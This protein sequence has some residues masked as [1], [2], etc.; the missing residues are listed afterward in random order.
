M[1]RPIA[2][3]SGYGIVLGV[4]FA[5]G[6]MLAAF[7]TDVGGA[8]ESDESLRR[9]VD[10]VIALHRALRPFDI[11]VA[12]E[13]GRV[14]L[15]GSVDSGLER[16]LAARLARS[17]GGVGAVDNRLLVEPDRARWL[18]RHSAALGAR[19][20]VAL[21]LAVAAQLRSSHAV[22][23]LDVDVSVSGGTVVLRGFAPSRRAQETAGR[24]AAR[25]FGVRTVDNRI[26]VAHQRAGQGMRRPLPWLVDHWLQ[27]KVR[28]ALLYASNVEGL[29]LEVDVADGVVILSGLVANRTELDLA[30]E[31]AAGIGGVRA[32]DSSRIRINV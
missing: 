15:T 1:M 31:I 27:F 29:D 13:H 20:D 6:L 25:T 8:R 7:P 9:Q 26:A 2:R 14:R 28:S 23:A 16:E 32:V 21:A 10:V 4:G 19:G 17:I 24:I 3:L 11:A 5:I 18:G 12:V 30:V 22:A